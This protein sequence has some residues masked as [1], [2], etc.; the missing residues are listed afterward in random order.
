MVKGTSK[1]LIVIKSFE[2]GQVTERG[3]GIWKGQDTNFI[4]DILQ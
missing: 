3:H 4:T 1:L 2:R